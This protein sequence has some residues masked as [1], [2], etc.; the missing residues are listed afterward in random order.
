MHLKPGPT[1]YGRHRP[2]RSKCKWTH[3][4][5]GSQSPDGTSNPCFAMSYLAGQVDFNLGP[6]WDQTA[7]NLDPLNVCRKRGSCAVACVRTSFS[8]RG[9]SGC[10]PFPVSPYPECTNSVC[11]PRSLPSP[12]GPTPN[13]ARQWKESR[14]GAACSSPSSAL[15]FWQSGTPVRYRPTAVCVCACRR[16]MPSGGKGR[17]KSIRCL[18]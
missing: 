1:L 8:S 16:E 6:T 3:T 15:W 13:L 10:S 2:K 5:P 7:P 4:L 9:V 12:A 17:G 14:N 11:S 18:L